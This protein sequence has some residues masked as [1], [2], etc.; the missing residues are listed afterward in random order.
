MEEQYVAIVGS[1]T[2][3]EVVLEYMIRLGRTYTDMGIGVSSGDAFD[4][5]R[6]G[7][8]GARQSRRFSE[9][10]PRIFL[11]KSH[12]NGVPINQ[13]H[14][15]IDARELH[16]HRHMAE[17]M[18]L[19]A[20]GSWNGLNEF[21]KDLHIRNV[22]QIHGGYLDNRVIACILWAEPNGRDKVRGGTNTAFQI[23]KKAGIPLIVNLYHQ[24]GIEWAKKFLAENEQSYPYD[25]IDWRQIHKW[26]DPRLNDFEE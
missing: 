11:N 17:A 14:G 20:R 5:D 3:P 19:D 1:R 18:A 24:D 7:W 8:Y 6:A 10:P 15:F 9:V 21:G 13:L 4:C 25:D 2:A 12:R 26:D 23:A 16:A 22:Y